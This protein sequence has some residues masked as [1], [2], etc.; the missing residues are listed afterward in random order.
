MRIDGENNEGYWKKAVNLVIKILE[1]LR[2]FEF[3]ITSIE[4]PEMMQS[5]SQNPEKEMEKKLINDSGIDGSHP[6]NE[7]LPKGM[8]QRRKWVRIWSYMKPKRDGGT[9]F[10]DLS[11]MIKK[12]SLMKKLPNDPD[13]LSKIEKAGLAGMLKD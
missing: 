1:K 11:A 13:T 5:V 7:V 3:E 4:P 8:A 9:S 6:K 12:D 10:K 2:E